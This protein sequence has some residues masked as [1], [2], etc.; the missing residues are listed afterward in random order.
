MNGEGKGPASF[1]CPMRQLI[2]D[3]SQYI[4]PHL[5]KDKLNEIA[6]ALK[7]DPDNQKC[8]ISVDNLPYPPPIN[9]PK[10]LSTNIDTIPTIFIDPINGQDVIDSHD[11]M[12]HFGD[13]N[14]PFKS[15]QYGLNYI[16]SHY[17]EKSD[18]TQI[19]LRQGVHYLDETLYFGPNDSNLKISSYN[20]E[21]A[22][23]SGAVPLSNLDW[24]LYKKENDNKDIYSAVIPK[25]VNITEIPGLRVN[26]TRAIRARYPNANP[27]VYPPGFGSSLQAKEWYGAIEDP[28]PDIIYY[29]GTPNRE[30]NPEHSFEHYNIG[31]GGTSCFNFEPRAGFRCST[32]NQTSQDLQTYQI[33]TGMIYNTKDLPNAPYANPKGG[34]VQVW[35][36]K[37]WDS[38]MFEIGKYDG[39]KQNIS[40]SKGGFQDGTGSPTGDAYYVENIMEELDYE[41]EWFYNES[42]RTLYYKMNVSNKSPDS[43]NLVFEA[44]KIKVLKNF[45][46]TMENPVEN[47][48]IS[49][50]TYRDTAI[51]YMDPHGIPSGIYCFYLGFTIFDGELYL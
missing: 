1:D 6:D 15:I 27:E 51:T 31:I 38:W 23:I 22:I 46:G 2:L 44:T 21:D 48:E 42:T 12:A 26:S 9:K 28:K 3:Y 7:G 10:V 36:P 41:N 11:D 39:N 35:R 32:A 24:K 43:A 8:D 14:K 49:G 30:D 37:H 16:R 47:V 4:Q 40:F 25:S 5:S 20:G 29:V 50:I 33:P 45:T 34:I 19:L 18:K 13:I 17:K